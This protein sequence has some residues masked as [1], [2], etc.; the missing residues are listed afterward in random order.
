MPFLYITESKDIFSAW[1]AI[2]A[3]IVG[4]VAGTLAGKRLLLRIPERIFRRVVSAVLLG[5]GVL[6]VVGQ[7]K[8]LSR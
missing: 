6:L 5:V 2:L 8:G 4:V 3:A 1:P 7:V